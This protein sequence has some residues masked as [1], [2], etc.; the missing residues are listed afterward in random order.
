MRV[1][2]TSLALLGAATLTASALTTPALSQ[3]QQTLN[4]QAGSDYRRADAA[5][6]VQYRSAM[7]DARRGGGNAA[8]LLLAS[9]RAWL[10]FRDSECRRVAQQYEG[11]SMQP[12]QYSGC[13]AQLTRARTRQLKGDP[14]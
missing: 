12:M 7:A 11:G 2:L 14:H 1:S 4:A 8:A 9:Q 10:Q 13:L 6:N 3:T 5:L